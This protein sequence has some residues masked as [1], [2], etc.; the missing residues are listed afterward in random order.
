MSVV[1]RPISLNYRNEM[2]WEFLRGGFNVGWARNLNGGP[3]NTDVIY[4]KS[5]AGAKD[6]W[7]VW[8]YGAFLDVSLPGEWTF[9]NQLSGQYTDEPLIAAEQLGLAGMTTVR[10][11]A[12]RE[13]AADIGNIYRGEIWTPQWVKDVNFLAFYDH[14]SGK[15]LH[16]L[17]GQKESLLLRSTGLGGRLNLK[18]NFVVAVD[19]AYAFDDA[20]TTQ[21]GPVTG[22]TSGSGKVNA[23]LY[24]RF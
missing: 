23:M 15:M 5:R 19:L 12:E 18:N 11:Y 20:R 14:A 8:R 4:A 10:G 7:D 1:S 17:A 13:M 21:T 3:G 16:T 24:Y 22:T 9:R 6:D 2:T